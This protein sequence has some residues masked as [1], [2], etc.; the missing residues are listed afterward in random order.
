MHKP[1][2]PFSGVVPSPERG[3]ILVLILVLVRVLMLVL[4]PVLKDGYPECTYIRDSG[5]A[6]SRY[7][8]QTNTGMRSR[9]S[10]SS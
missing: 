2:R 3:C 10:T 1:R 7:I 8:M 6:E 4:V 5:S 9:T